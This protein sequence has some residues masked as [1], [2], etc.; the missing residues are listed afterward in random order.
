MC[1]GGKFVRVEFLAQI[2]FMWIPE[3]T[4]DLNPQSWR[5]YPI[6]ER[7]VF[8]WIGLCLATN[9]TSYLQMIIN[10]H[11]YFSSIRKS[12]MN[13]NFNYIYFFFISVIMD[14]SDVLI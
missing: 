1:S 8:P 7:S 4:S 3:S 5:E 14:L 6:P 2:Y 11:G 13:C 10:L 9:F 12:L